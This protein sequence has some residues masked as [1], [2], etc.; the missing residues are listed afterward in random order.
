MRL[1]MRRDHHNHPGRCKA[2]V[3]TR[4][5]RRCVGSRGWMEGGYRFIRVDGRKIAVH[6]H[7]MELKLG[8]KLTSAEIVHHVD[9]NPLN[10]DPDNLV[11]LTRAQ[12][13]RSACVFVAQALEAR[14]VEAGSRLPAR[15]DDDL[16]DRGRA[17]ATVLDSCS[18]TREIEQTVTDCRI[19]RLRLLMEHAFVQRRVN[20]AFSSRPSLFDHDTGL[21]W[22]KCIHH[23]MLNSSIRVRS[24]AIS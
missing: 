14:R 15:G 2:Q 13:Q 11:I 21:T 24:G 23:T 9:W 12:H 7:V 3:A 17:G 6:R 19:R 22:P 4:H 16:R 18:A 1:R 20:F 5:N 10:N 8:R